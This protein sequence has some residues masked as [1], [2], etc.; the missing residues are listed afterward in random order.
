MKKS[1]DWGAMLL[2]FFLIIITIALIIGTVNMAM[3]EEM[4]K[5]N[6]IAGIVCCVIVAGMTLFTIIFIYCQ[7][8]KKS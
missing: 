5:T 7:F 6:I 1:I 8:K 2:C 3:V 4:S